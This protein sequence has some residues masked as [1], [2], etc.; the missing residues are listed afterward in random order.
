MTPSKIFLTKL[1]R[2]HTYPS[3]IRPSQN[4]LRPPPLKLLDRIEG[5]VNENVLKSN[6]CLLCVQL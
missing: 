6:V 1:R 2:H 5:N 4:V 3:Q